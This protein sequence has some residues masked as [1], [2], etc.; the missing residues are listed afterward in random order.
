M[1]LCTVLID[2]VRGLVFFQT[3]WSPDEGYKTG[4][5]RALIAINRTV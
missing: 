2:C 3:V 4:A 1:A 5:M